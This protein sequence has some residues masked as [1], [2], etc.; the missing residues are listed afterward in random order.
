MVNTQCLYIGG[1]VYSTISSIRTV[2]S[3]NASENMID[4]FKGATKKAKKSAIGFTA[5]VGLANGG[6]MASF[7]VSY[8]ALTLYGAFKLYSQVRA[9]G[10][11]P[12]NIVPDNASCEI[13]GRKVFGALMGISF[14]GM[15]LAQIGAAAEAFT[16]S[17][18]ACHPAIL[19]I[20]RKLGQE[21]EL[22]LQNESPEDPEGGGEVILKKQE[23]PLPKYAIDSSSDIGKKPTS[24]N[25]EIVFNDVSFE[26]PTRPDSKVFDHMSLTIKAGQTVALV[27]P[28]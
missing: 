17:R 24:V 18:S 22:P 14:G 4:D 2:F 7:L 21:D 28:R 12:S 19:A 23:I 16:G 5:W 20:E 25:G 26:Y 13:T 10:C 1:I 15:G 6:M 27:G 8:I 11:D 3:L 9:D